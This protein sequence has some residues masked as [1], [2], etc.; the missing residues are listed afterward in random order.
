[1]EHTIVIVS[2]AIAITTSYLANKYY[3]EAKKYKRQ[4]EMAIEQFRSLNR[5][6]ATVCA[7]YG[8]SSLNYTNDI[9]GNKVKLKTTV[10][11]EEKK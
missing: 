8:D 5:V 7:K 3:L 4:K 6:F 9:F 2:A 1:M 11:K 10:I